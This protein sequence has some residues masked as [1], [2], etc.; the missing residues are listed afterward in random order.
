MKPAH[1][2]AAPVPTLVPAGII[3]AHA[4]SPQ[5]LAT[6]I[7]SSSDHSEF[8]TIELDMQTAEGRRVCQQVLIDMA[9]FW[10]GET[11]EYLTLYV[12]DW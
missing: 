1:I 10:L 11:V 9:A 2:P 12:R 4:P 5:N 7:I 6:I 8:T 3:L